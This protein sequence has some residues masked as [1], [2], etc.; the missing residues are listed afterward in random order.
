[1]MTT[2][3]CILVGLVVVVVGLAILVGIVLGAAWLSEWREWVKSIIVG[4]VVLYVVAVLGGAVYVIGCEVSFHF[5]WI[6]DCPTCE[7]DE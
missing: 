7:V 1:M 3:I 5:G 4:L 2:L 6:D